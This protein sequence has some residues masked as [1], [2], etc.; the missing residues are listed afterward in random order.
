M[1]AAAEADLV[2]SFYNPRSA[3]RTWQLD[4]ARRILGERRSP[5]TPVAVVTDAA[6]A[7]QTATVTTLEALDTATVGM[8]SVVLVGNSA[9][10]VVGGRM[11]T[12][13]GYLR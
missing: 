4:A 11:V 13:R 10:R 2:V 8:A 5:A 9:T 3:R 12:P 7:S 1:R 6:R